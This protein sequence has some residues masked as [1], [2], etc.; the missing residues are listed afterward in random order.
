[1]PAVYP[2][3]LRLNDCGQSLLRQAV[4]YEEGGEVAALSELGDAQL[5]GAG[6]GV[7]VTVAIAIALGEA[8]GT[9]LAI[10]TPVSV[11]TSSAI[12][13]SA[14]KPIM[15]R[16][17]DRRQESSPRGHAGPSSCRSSV[18]PPN[19]VGVSNR[20]LPANHQ[21]TTRVAVRSLGRYLRT[22][23]LAAA[24]LPSYTTS[25]D[26]IPYKQTVPS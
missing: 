7:P 11:P 6:P 3:W 15:S 20:T 21:M 12:I 23:S 14:T 9:L 26:V 4:R 22:A 1:V 8:L 24:P 18:G 2:L 16:R 13:R 25:W 19:Q 17:A 10:A 5:D